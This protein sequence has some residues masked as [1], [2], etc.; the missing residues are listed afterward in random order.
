MEKL[1]SV[2]GPT[3]R[4]LVDKALE[5][6]K[7]LMARDYHNRLMYWGWVSFIFGMLAGAFAVAWVAL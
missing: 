4:Y 3:E 6:A 5:E 7:L 1:M 2:F